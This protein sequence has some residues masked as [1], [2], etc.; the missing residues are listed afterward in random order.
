[1]PLAE[2]SSRARRWDVAGGCLLRHRQADHDLFRA[3][4]AVPRLA[5]VTDTRTDRSSLATVRT[6][7]LVTAI[8]GTDGAVA[9]GSLGRSGVNPSRA[10]PATPA[11]STPPRHVAMRPR[12]QR[13]L[14]RAGG[15]WATA[16][17]MISRRASRLATSSG[18][19]RCA[20][21]GHSIS[22]ASP[23]SRGC[24]EKLLPQALQLPMRRFG[25]D[26]P[27]RAP[28]ASSAIRVSL[29]GLKMASHLWQAMLTLWPAL[30][31]ALIRS[32]STAQGAPHPGHWWISLSGVSRMRV[33]AHHPIAAQSR[34]AWYLRDSK[35]CR[36]STAAAR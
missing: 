4:S 28:R 24:R 19:I 27:G 20:Q 3:P 22:T 15:S 11:R 14:G 35:A 30:L 25:C 12:I 16:L 34:P 32:R 36:H 29:S 2:A 5:S 18:N 23:A 13:R 9:K 10:A 17:A 26:L 31:A 6:A 7:V 21:C 1:M 33:T 8:R